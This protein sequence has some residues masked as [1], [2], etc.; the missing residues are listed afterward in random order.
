V[1]NRLSLLGL[2]KLDPAIDP[3][4]KKMDARVPQTSLRSLRKLDCVP[5]HDGGEQRFSLLGSWPIGISRK[6]ATVQLVGWSGR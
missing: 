5:A 1:L 6:P 4:R 2:A 3:F